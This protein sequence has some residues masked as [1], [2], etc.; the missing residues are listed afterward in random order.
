VSK[1]HLTNDAFAECQ[2]RILSKCNGSELTSAV[3][4]A[5][6]SGWLCQVSN[7]RQNILCRVSRYVECF[8]LPS[9]TLGKLYLCRVLDILL[10]VNGFAVGKERV[11]SSELTCDVR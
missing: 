2:S 5:L 9:T 7:T 4:G 10:S 11:S 1:I 3:D 8:Y 6:P